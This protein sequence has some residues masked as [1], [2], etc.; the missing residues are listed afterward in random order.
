MHQITPNFN[1][2]PLLQFSPN[3]GNHFPYNCFVPKF[4]YFSPQ[5][6]GIQL[7]NITQLNYPGI[8]TRQ[9]SYITPQQWNPNKIN[10]Q[11]SNT[12]M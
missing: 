9:Y 10:T 5:Y 8:A 7:Q 2:N 11:Q 12:P 3:Y 6:Y 4:C 1:Q